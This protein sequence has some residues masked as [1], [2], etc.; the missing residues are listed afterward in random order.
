MT[1]GAAKPMLAKPGVT[2]MVNVPTAIMPS[3]TISPS[4]RPTRSMKAPRKIAPS[5]RIRKPTPN[6]ASDSI[7]DAAGLLF[8]KNARPM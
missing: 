7:R 2:A 3:V 4:R 8:G 5:G 6:V 1:R